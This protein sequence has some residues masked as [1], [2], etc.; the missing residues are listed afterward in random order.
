M[1]HVLPSVKVAHKPDLK[2]QKNRASKNQGVR[3]ATGEKQRATINDLVRQRV[4][5]NVS[6]L[7]NEVI[8]D[9]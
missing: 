5:A 6:P 7:S 8:C 4:R 9:R 1:G 2:R 3:I